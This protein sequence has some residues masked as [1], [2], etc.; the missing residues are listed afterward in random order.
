MNKPPSL[1]PADWQLGETTKFGM[2]Y[3]KSQVPYKKII[4]DSFKRLEILLSN[5]DVVYTH[6]FWGEY[7][8]PEHVQVNYAIIEL[9]KKI[10][11]EVWVFGCVS[12]E[13]F[14]MMERNKHYLDKTPKF[15]LTNLDVYKKLKDLYQ[16]YGCWTYFDNFRLSNFDIF[17]NLVKRIT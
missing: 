17:I 7:G 12:K 9:S 3:G 14:L 15:L 13:T 2:K 6:N 4:F 16:Y 5:T 10:N 8:H 1:I 11:F